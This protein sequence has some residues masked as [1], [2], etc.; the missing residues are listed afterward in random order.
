MACIHCTV[1]YNILMKDWLKHT[2]EEDFF[3][4]ILYIDIRKN[5]YRKYCEKKDIPYSLPGLGTYDSFLGSMKNMLCSDREEFA[6]NMKLIRVLDVLEDKKKYVVFFRLKVQNRVYDKKAAFVCGEEKD[7]IIVFCEDITD[8]AGSEGEKMHGKERESAEAQVRLLQEHAAY[9]AH[10]TRASL[11]SIYGNLSILRQ[12]R[13]RGDGRLDDAFYAAEYLLCL[14]NS[15]L[16]ISMLENDVSVTKIEAATLEELIRYPEKIFEQSAQEKG[17][18]LQFYS[19]KPVYQ[20][21]YLNKDIVCQIMINLLSNAIKYTNDGGQVVCRLSETYL[22]EKRVKLSLEVMDTGIGMEE[23]FLSAAWN[24]YAREQRMKGSTGA[25]LGLMITKRMVELL[26]GSID[27]VS[28]TGAGTKVSV[29]L[30]A[31]GDDV[32]Y[33]RAVPAAGGRKAEEER[34]LIRRA[35]VA[36]D[37]EANMKIICRYL[38][39]LGVTADRAYNGGEAIELY[40]KAEA[41]YYHVML[42]DINMPQMDGMEAIRRIRN[43]DRTGKRM[44]IIAVTAQMPDKEKKEALFTN[45]DGYLMKPYRLE[46]IRSILLK[47]L[48]CQR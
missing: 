27:I 34:I 32:L 15:T 24:A 41:D 40:E 29:E 46:D 19:G 38:E 11:H 14:M 39:Q 18:S 42:I 1:N 36:E 25:G 30:E 5:A 10:E 3:D 45:I 4:F 35:L 23:E 26:H 21:L 33:T 9:L 22:E 44:P 47:L 16:D 7:T 37:E 2:L 43:I 6:E 28:Q 20:Y 13:Y 8:M 31:D 48:K 17:I 12:D